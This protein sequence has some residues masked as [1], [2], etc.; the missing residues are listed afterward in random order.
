MAKPSVASW[1][2]STCRTPEPS[3]S[4]TS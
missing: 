4:R 3:R 1:V 2:M